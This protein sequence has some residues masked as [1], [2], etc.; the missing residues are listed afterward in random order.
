MASGKRERVTT[1]SISNFKL[2]PLIDG[3]L[4]PRMYIRLLTCAQISSDK[5]MDSMPAF[6]EFHGCAKKFTGFKLRGSISL[7]ESTSIFFMNCIPRRFRTEMVKSFAYG[8]HNC[9][10]A[11]SMCLESRKAPR[12]QNVMHILREGVSL[13]FDSNNTDYYFSKG[14]KIEYILSA[15]LR[16][17]EE[18]HETRG[19]GAFIKLF[20]AE[21]DS[22][23]CHPKDDDYK[24]IRDQLLGHFDDEYEEVNNVLKNSNIVVDNLNDNN[25]K[26]NSNNDDD[27]ND[28]YIDDDY[29]NVN[30]EDNIPIDMTSYDSTGWETWSPVKE[31]DWG[32]VYVIS[33]NAF[34]YYDDKEEDGHII[35]FGTPLMSTSI[36]VHLNDLRKPRFD[37]QISSLHSL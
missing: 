13:K 36:S 4:T 12:I 16:M 8:F 10:H 18:E 33:K 14:G 7:E 20:K 5:C 37:G 15:L 3:V 9:L 30:N 22:L 1:D 11:V 26:S 31:C 2:P 21:L 24:F 28:E 27:N 32:L 17:S 6:D 23:P 34:G 29:D 35:Y 19:N 25:S